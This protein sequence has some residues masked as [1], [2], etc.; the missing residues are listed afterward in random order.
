MDYKRIYNQLIERRRLRPA[1]LDN[2]Y[3]EN[4]HVIPRSIDKTLEFDKNNL[5]SL[6]AREH[7]IAHL[8]LVMIYREFKSDAYYKMLYAFNYM[9]LSFRK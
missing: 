3:T 2:E 8:L 6:T 9:Q 5:V 1:K 7:F 4:H